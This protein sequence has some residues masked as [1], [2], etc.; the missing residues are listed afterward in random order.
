M[1]KTEKNGRF[2][3]EFYQYI[4]N[5][6]IEYKNNK[7]WSNHIKLSNLL[8]NPNEKTVKNCKFVCKNKIL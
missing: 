1:I 3:Y 7:L 2:I 6:N 4:I 5:H 8:I